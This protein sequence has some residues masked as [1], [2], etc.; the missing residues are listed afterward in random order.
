MRYLSTR[1]EKVDS[2]RE[3]LFSGLADDGGLFVPEKWPT[4]H[5]DQIDSNISYIDLASKPPVKT[6]FH[7]SIPL[8]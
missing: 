3:V 2:F 6:L 1:G 8:E 7:I 5:V 4:L